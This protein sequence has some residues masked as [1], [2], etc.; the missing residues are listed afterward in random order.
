PCTAYEATLQ[1]WLLRKKEHRGE[2]RERG[3]RLQRQH[4]QCLSWRPWQPLDGEEGHDRHLGGHED[5]K[6]VRGGPLVGPVDDTEPGVMNEHD[7]EGSR[8]SGRPMVS[9]RLA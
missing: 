1:S 3:G 7:D 8:P 9:H 2:C 6:K 5:L 4:L